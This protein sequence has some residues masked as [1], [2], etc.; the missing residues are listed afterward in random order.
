VDE[1][2]GLVEVQAGIRWQALAADPAEPLD[3]ARAAILAW[4][5]D[6]S[7]QATV[8]ESVCLNA[9]GPDGRMVVACVESLTL[10]MSDGQMRRASRSVNP[11]LFR[12]TVGGYGLCGILYSVTLRLESLANC[13]PQAARGIGHA[14][15]VIDM[16]AERADAFLRIAELELASYRI[17]VADCSARHVSAGEPVFLGRKQGESIRIELA[18]T[19]A[20]TLAGKVRLADACRRIIGA[21]IDHGGGFALE[22]ARHA[23]R[24]QVEACYPMISA[25]FAEKRRHDGADTLQNAW[26]RQVRNLLRRGSPE[27][28]RAA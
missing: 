4:A 21:A 24:E 5:A 7:A 10:V 26:Y 2:R 25:F 27:S 22:A 16:P 12:V 13:L 14:D 6:P 15:L 11:D 18:L 8:G 28:R 9:P 19:S 20:A 1:A 3:R 17:A 23:S